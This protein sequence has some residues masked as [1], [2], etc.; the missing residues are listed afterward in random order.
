MRRYLIL[1]LPGL[2]LFTYTCAK[3]GM[4][5]GGPA[6]ETSPFVKEILPRS[7]STLADAGTDIRITF[8]EPMKKRTVETGIAVNP[9]CMWQERYWEDNS[10]VLVPLNRLIPNTTYLVSISNQ[11]TDSHG[12]KMQSTFVA[13]F[14]TGPAIDA[15]RISGHVRWKNLKVSDAVVVVFDADTLELESGFPVETPVYLTLTDN[16]GLFEVPF[17]DTTRAYWVLSFMDKNSNAEFDEDE[18]VGCFGGTVTFESTGERGGIGILLC[19]ET[20]CGSVKG[21]VDS[22]ALTVYPK[23]GVQASSTADSLLTYEAMAGRTGEF[24]ITCMEPG[25]YRVGFYSDIDSDGKVDAGD[26]LLLELRDPV[27][28]RAC[29][30]LML[31]GISLPLPEGWGERDSTAV[32]EGGPGGTTVGETGDDSDSTSYAPD[33]KDSLR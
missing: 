8:S 28:V 15:G 24:A 7:G 27:Q 16:A 9:P 2:C 12:V 30:D 14:S 20:L 18:I 32:P 29:A 17:V 6:D 13:G 5:G 33:E 25:P 31:E 4:P 23:V 1:L 3:R 10:Y 19:K 22:L 11:A 21:V 26:S